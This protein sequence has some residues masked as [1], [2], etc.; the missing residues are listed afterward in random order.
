MANE[1]RTGPV[2]PLLKQF[3][4]GQRITLR[5]LAERVKLDPGNYSRVERGVFAPPPRDKLDE[6][7]RLLEVSKEQREE[8][9]DRAD[10]DRG[11]LPS[12]LQR[13]EVLVR[14]LPILFRA[15]RKGDRE[16][17]DKFIESVRKGGDKA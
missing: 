11:I 5:D 15:V 14:E 7:L 3:R 2:G 17:L 12:D 13:D 4:L 16:A 6:I 1:N 8:I 10:V 9:M